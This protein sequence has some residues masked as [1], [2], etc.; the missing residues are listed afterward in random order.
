MDDET[1]N[2]SKR[3]ALEN[4]ISS[5]SV[6][7][8]DPVCVRK[9]SNLS[10]ISKKYVFDDESF[11]PETL[12]N[13]MP[14]HSPKLS[15]LI[16]NINE[17]DK[18][19]MENHGKMFKHFIFSDLKTGNYGVKL[20][21]SA[22]I[23]NGMKLGYTAELKKPEA[24]DKTVGGDDS[25]NKKRYKKIEIFPDE[26]LNKGKSNNF[27]LL[28]STVV[29]DQPI[30]IAM[31][32]TI[33]QKYNQRPENVN[34]ELVR[35][36]I[37]DSGYK[38]GIDLFDV[39]YVHIFEP[40]I[41]QSDK[42]QVIGRATRT[43]GQKGLEFHPK[44]GWPLDVFVYDLSIPEK[45]QKSF[46]DSS[47]AI[48]LYM[49]AMNLD[50]RQLNFA[51]DLEKTSIFGSVDYDLNK[52]IHSFSIPVI[53][54]ELSNADFDL[55]YGG[56]KGAPKKRLVIRTDRP[57]I[58]VNQQ[59]TIFGSDNRKNFENMR[60]YISN[61]FGEFKW[62]VV[63]MENL[64][65]EK[66]SG[67]SGQL[68]KYTPTQDFIRNYFTPLNPV[69]GMLL[70]HSVGTGKTCTAIAAATSNFEKQEYTILWVTRTTL[71]SDI[72]KNMFD[73]V[74]N[75]SIKNKIIYENLKIPD[76][77]KKRMKLLSKS[78]KIRPISYKQFSN[79]VSKENAFYEKLVKINGSDDPLRKTLLIIDEA[80]KLYGG[81]DL[82]S[83]ERPDM[84]ALHKAIMHSYQHSGRDSVRLLL[85]TAT[86]VTKDP[87]ELIK[88]INLCKSENEQMPCRFS[89]FSESYLT[90][91]GKFTE[92]GREK[93][94]DDISGYISYL[95]REKD[96][97]QFAQP[98][99]HN[100]EVPITDNI[101]QA[102]RFDSKLVRDY[103]SSDVSDL[104]EMIVNE[105]KKIEGEL[106]EI[107]KYKF[108]Y[109]KEEV[110][111]ELEGKQ[112]NQCEKI[113]DN[114]IKKMVAEAKEEVKKIRE[115][116]AEIRE[117]IKNR[118]LV[119]KSALSNIKENVDKYQEEYE[120]YQGTLLYSLKN[121]CGVKIRGD[122]QLN[123]MVGEHPTIKKYDDNI[124]DYNNE[125]QR[126]NGE[127]KQQLDKYK[128]RITYLKSLLKDNLNSLEK[129]VVKVTLRDERKTQKNLMKLKRKDVDTAENELNEKIKKTE[130]KRRS[131]FK[132]IRKTVKNM[133]DVEKQKESDIKRREKKLRTTLRKQ[134]DFREEIKDDL[135]VNIVN[136]YKPKILE[137]LVDLDEKILEDE[138]V[139][140]AK[141]QRAA[142]R[143][144]EKQHKKIEKERV[145]K[146]KKQES[147]N[148]KETRRIEKEK[149]RSEKEKRT[150]KKIR[151]ITPK[152]V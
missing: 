144:A 126:L 112:L 57:P 92:D 55:I 32:K 43:C 7:S 94:L 6:M 135:L 69:K 17:L 142:E 46:L 63:K 147:E 36:I 90:N 62:D 73:Q 136:K 37:M 5:Q 60:E 34:G 109:L 140:L 152:K 148:K 111:G 150:T 108:N 28:S 124:T 91:D 93:Y 78:W 39:K 145:M 72:W 1:D 102:E 52:N 134:K 44:K 23:A 129:S 3:N 122:S 66:T 146:L 88:L 130:K 110:C 65:V 33:L 121:K 106:S 143:E 61:Y 54:D 79:L 13:D 141:K 71:K 30:T 97:R 59:M 81:E 116:I 2:I 58:V 9:K 21:A 117:L 15:R 41:T 35:I 25:L 67:G 89:D 14:D 10:K 123:G 103:L 125:I 64:C 133:I 138:E 12:L 98:R 149:K 119:R 114:N 87:M 70:H 115:K 24:E 38:E 82:S 139:K 49:K 99:I 131:K 75:E 83:I 56:N 128:R 104:K 127:L 47:T 74:C 40:S 19:D 48:E 31:K 101:E 68:M 50:I 96:A 16:K 8:Y 4:L 11:S 120:K 100:I 22:L 42:K 113:V 18:N 20:L 77:Q 53:D 132:K 85:M 151:R 45:I 80:H 26:V 95:N 105:G 107:D 86:P 118:N 27:Y 51:Y 76:E 29:Y 84:D 137:D